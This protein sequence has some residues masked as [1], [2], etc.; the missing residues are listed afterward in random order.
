MAG[1]PTN[2][3]L[4]HVTEDQRSFAEIA[5][6]WSKPANEPIEIMME[7]LIKSFWRG[8]Y[9]HDGNSSVFALL[10]PD[11]LSL[12]RKPGNYA[13][14]RNLVVKIGYNLD[15]HVTA[16][17]K[18]HNLFR[19]E[20]A[21]VLC[22]MGEYCPWPWDGSDDGL[23]G[24]ST[25]SFEM[26]PIGMREERYSQWRIRRNDFAEWYRASPLHITA[27]LHQF[28][29][30]QTD[31]AKDRGELRPSFAK[32]QEA[33]DAELAAG[34]RIDGLR[35]RERNKR[36]SDRLIK[37]GYNSKELPHERTYREFFNRG[38]GKAEKRG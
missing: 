5:Q 38:P 33:I 35:P 25:I 15:S 23:V 17:R 26:W 2:P 14:S 36:L 34:G 30:A 3:L 1:N 31:K 13:T 12:E 9:E 11:S 24:L 22:G 16:E 4:A 7:A 10:Q 37:R 27:R 6:R 19:R 29:P 20:V 28:W 18:E 21:E 8:E 32:I